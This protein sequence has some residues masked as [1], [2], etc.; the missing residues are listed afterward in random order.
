MCR[1]C[2]SER[3]ITVLNFN[4]LLCAWCPSRF[5]SL[6]SPLLMFNRNKFVLSL[7]FPLCLLSSPISLLYFFRLSLSSLF[8]PLP[9][10]WYNEK[11]GSVPCLSL[12]CGIISGMLVTS[13][14]C[15]LGDRKSEMNSGAQINF[16][17]WPA[18]AVS[19]FDV[20]LAHRHICRHWFMFYLC[21]C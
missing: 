9:Q 16:L 10:L 15:R 12:S 18:E 4:F 21:L 20:L 8:A 19:I 7:F 1:R 3:Q 5:L 2:L 6:E 11:Q 13:H 14:D 17:V